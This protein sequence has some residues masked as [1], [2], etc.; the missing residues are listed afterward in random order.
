MLRKFD[1][2]RRDDFFLLWQQYVPASQLGFDF[3]TQKREF[4]LQ[5]YFAIYPVLP[6]SSVL[7]V[8]PGPA[9]R[10]SAHT[11]S[12][13]HELALR[14]KVFKSYLEG[15]GAGL[16][17]TPEFLPY[18]ALPYVPQP[19][20]HPSFEGLFA[21][22]RW[23]DDQ[24]LR[25]KEFLDATGAARAA[26]PGL[27][28]L[29]LMYEEHL[30]NTDA[31]PRLSP[32]SKAMRASSRAGGPR[33]HHA[34]REGR[35]HSRGSGG[36]AGGGGST[37]PPGILGQLPPA[38]ARASAAYHG[39][40]PASGGGSSSGG[41][42]GAA[43]A[44]GADS[45]QLPVGRWPPLPP[46]ASTSYGSG[47]AASAAVRASAE[48][49][50]KPT[51]PVRVSARRSGAAQGAG[52]ADDNYSDDGFIRDLGDDDDDDEADEE[53]QQALAK[54]KA[55]AAS[56]EQFGADDY[57]D[58]DDEELAA[59]L[60]AT[61]RTN[62]TSKRGGSARQRLGMSLEALGGIMAADGGKAHAVLR[63]SVT[64]LQGGGGGTMDEAAAEELAA[65][66]AAVAAALG[67]SGGFGAGGEAVAGGAAAGLAPL[68]YRKV[69]AD[70]QGSD[71]HLAARLLQALRW[72]LTRSRPG[73][74]RWAVLA[75]FIEADLLDCHCPL[76]PPPPS[77]ARAGASWAPEGDEAEPRSLLQALAGQQASGGGGAHAGGAEPDG[78]LTDELA[79]LSNAVASDRLGRNYLML[80][81]GGAVAALL[82]LLRR[83]PLK[84]PLEERMS[85]GAV[86]A[87]VKAA[88]AG[89]G[90]QEAGGGDGGAAAAEEQEQGAGGRSWRDDSA[91]R[92]A[93]VAL[94]KLSLK[95]RAQSQMIRQGAVGW[96][97]D[98]LQDLD[99][100]SPTAVEY[101]AALLMNLCLRS[102]GR[103]AA[104]APGVVAP[105][106]RLCEALL[107]A[108][109]E[110]VR[111][112]THGIL[113]SVFSRP[114]VR[115]AALARG[116]SDL[117]EATQQ[118]APQ[119]FAA[120]IE[121]VLRQ[122]HHPDADEAAGADLE[123]DDEAAPDGDAD[124]D[125]EDEAADDPYADVDG[126]AAEAGGRAGESL[127]VVPGVPHGEELLCGCGYLASSAEARS[128]LAAVRCS[129]ALAA[130]ANAAAAGAAPPPGPPGPSR[131][132][133]ARPG[134]ARP[135][136][137][138]V[139]ASASRRG[140]GLGAAAIVEEPQAED[141]GEEE[142]PGS[143]KAAPTGPGDDED[144]AGG[145]GLAAVH[146][147]L[148]ESVLLGTLPQFGTM[149]PEGLLGLAQA[150]EG[151]LGL[152][153][154][155]EDGDALE[156]AAAAYSSR[157]G[158]AASAT[159]RR[160]SA[161]TFALLAASTAGSSM[162]AAARA[163]HAASLRASRAEQLEGARAEP[164]IEAANSGVGGGV[165]GGAGV[166]P[167][168]LASTSRGGAFG[169]EA[170]QEHERAGL[171]TEPSAPSSISL[172][173]PASASSARRLSS[174]GLGAVGL[175]P[176]PPPGS[177]PGTAQQLEGASP[178]M[179][180]ARPLGAT[181]AGGPPGSSSG[182][183]RL[184][185]T[186]ASPS[187]LPPA[188]S[189]TSAHNSIDLAGGGALAGYGRPPASPLAHV[190]ATEAAAAA[191]GM[192]SPAA[193]AAERTSHPGT[194][195]SSRSI[196]RSSSGNTNAGAAAAA[197]GALLGG[198]VPAATAGGASGTATP[199]DRSWEPESS[200]LMALAQQR[201][202]AAG[203][204]ALGRSRDLSSSQQ[205]G[206]AGTPPRPP[207]RSASPSL[208][209]TAHQRLGTPA[210]PSLLGSPAGLAS[211]AS[212]AAASP[213]ALLRSRSGT[214]STGFGAGLPLAPPASS[215]PHQHP[216]GAPANGAGSRPA[217]GASVASVAAAGVHEGPRAGVPASARI[218]SPGAPVSLPSP[219]KAV[220]GVAAGAGGV[221]E[222][223]ALAAAGGAGGAGA[224]RSPSR[225][226][227]NGRS[228]IPKTR[229]G[230]PP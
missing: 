170:S 190:S 89:G 159:G 26:A 95:R 135:P 4:Y 119:Q 28:G 198:S 115:A 53:R 7:V 139:S 15:R 178:P 162:A 179:S 84:P 9:S 157:P 6:S 48:A 94:Q 145:G 11:S 85:A 82:A 134:S 34:S 56:A 61:G 40:R 69:K 10:L 195:M 167:A 44:A 217:S 3:E 221:E 110:Q 97:V 155:E 204:A 114:E 83:A 14:M 226:R 43:A 12:S 50:V 193:G 187:I 71:P 64:L 105:L 151:A 166:E 177:R 70:L 194:P 103:A 138:S 8:V 46:R 156:A 100:A 200:S 222:G 63:E 32:R 72:R 206:A 223:G 124:A 225:T 175:V 121:H 126:L 122:L 202:S 133:S 107:D 129:V 209:A 54:A 128:H 164:P 81:G 79:R 123:S 18:Y 23:V 33:P 140:A 196:R 117:L 141:E 229:M 186:G 205:A 21:G 58:M 146:A 78:R 137:S 174:G 52:S 189:P 182:A 203:V 17:H 183:R 91:T 216:G 109:N 227:S 116:T 90:G 197:G 171:I 180:A 201:A 92:Q 207:S 228:G 108:P 113:Y 161:S 199:V 88:A 74:D 188:T 62:A 220:T 144:D 191:G 153:A 152:E 168:S 215:P 60:N 101:G 66:G 20:H 169:S 68:N 181:T 30:A 185:G 19:E 106:L 67:R 35:P 218:M 98:F 77:P 99:S 45:A 154:A 1:E 127:A 118:S 38:H 93:L 158:T 142:L 102:A 210:G 5:V 104:A 112:Y 230:P 192:A 55:A 214:T 147:G 160:D 37:H 41:G 132:G 29:Y 13:R 219:A 39:P 150:M 176:T 86:A 80:P 213:A 75:C 120:Q 25:L 51:A 143:S 36:G 125:P 149:P 130:V 87:A 131:P 136:S 73:A 22:G 2:G 31:V 224:E 96:V 211:P 42:G 184:S 208:L 24:R 165:G 212:G 59:I 172:G 27:P 148:R 111:T 76:P 65:A 163:L 16:A 47:A 49:A 57:D 173:P